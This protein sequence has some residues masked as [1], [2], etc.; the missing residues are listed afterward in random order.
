METAKADS[1][2]VRAIPASSESEFPTVLAGPDELLTG[3]DPVQH[4]LATLIGNLETL[5]RTDR[6]GGARWRQLLNEARSM[7]S[8]VRGTA[9]RDLSD[10]PARLRERRESAGMTQRQLGERANLST[11]L[12][13]GIE[14][15]RK[16]ATPAT[17]RALMRVEALRLDSGDLLPAPMTRGRAESPNWWV[18]PQLDVVSMLQDLGRRMS[19][20]SGRIEQTHM[21][22]DAH[23]A[24]DWWE[25]A[26][27]PYYLS[28]YRHPMPLEHVA[29]TAMDAVG[30]VP[31]DV[32]A[33]GP[34]DGLM[35]T[36]FVQ[37]LMSHQVDRDLRYYLLDIS[38][39]L[40]SKAHR[41]A[42]DSLDAVRGV[43]VFGMF[44]NFHYLPLYE[45]L[46]YSPA[47]RRRIFTLIGATMNNLDDELRFFRESLRVAE[48]DD[49]LLVDFTVAFAP[50]S[51]RKRILEL[52]KAIE[53]PMTD[54]I[55]KWLSGPFRRNGQP[56]EIKGSYEL[57][58]DRMVPGSYSVDAKVEVV[59]QAGEKRE[60][61]VWRVT[62]Y[63]PE[64][65]TAWLDGLGWQRLY[66]TGFGPKSRNQMGLMLLRKR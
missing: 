2:T 15:G 40:L 38:Q 25:I 11:D 28:S 8:T 5:A 32:V 27:D 20:S 42:K 18:A 26:N 43:V 14:A 31:L 60:F 62:R 1:S 19:S 4:S 10:F 23:S 49:L 12:I 29:A 13:R 45:Q 33:L 50:P 37:A 63:D 52:D 36:R 64:Q 54:A 66:F 17:V 3:T 35:E 65:L 34:G 51:E 22:L 30:Q 58:T 55:L 9:P 46:F 24:R 57:D 61:F 39:P 44:G 47:K 16:R 6:G 59:D 56:R 53:Q 41:H 48:K 21:Y 7:L